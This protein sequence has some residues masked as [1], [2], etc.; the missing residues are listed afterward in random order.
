MMLFR[1]FFLFAFLARCCVRVAKRKGQTDVGALQTWA[2]AR[3]QR[4][5]AQVK[6]KRPTKIQIHQVPTKN[7]RSAALI[8]RTGRFAKGMNATSSTT[9]LTATPPPTLASALAGNA[10]SVTAE[11]FA[12][13]AQS[14]G[15]LMLLLLLGALLSRFDVI[16]VRPLVVLNSFVYKIGFVRF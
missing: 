14:G 4:E 5:A 10:P 16:G 1:L 15:S 12:K 13:A 2:R 6:P 7:A 11:S 8:E 9:S 3:S